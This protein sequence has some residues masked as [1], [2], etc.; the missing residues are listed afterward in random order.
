[1]KLNTNSN[2]KEFN[3]LSTK[4]KLNY[5]NDLFKVLNL[6]SYQPKNNNIVFNQLN[7]VVEVL[8]I[9]SNEL[10]KNIKSKKKSITEK[11]DLLK[12]NDIICEFGKAKSFLNILKFNYLNTNKNINVFNNILLIEQNLNKIKKIYSFDFIKLE[13]QKIKTTEYNQLELF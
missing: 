2:L 5:V 12:N 6:L 7:Y 8:S 9:F 11:S 4:N 13:Q 3:A 10:T 1:M